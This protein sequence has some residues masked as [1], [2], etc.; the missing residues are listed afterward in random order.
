MRRTACTSAGLL[1]PRGR[2]MLWAMLR[3]R[4]WAVIWP[5]MVWRRWVRW[6]LLTAGGEPSVQSPNHL[7]QQ[8]PQQRH[9]RPLD[10]FT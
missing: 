1:L 5:V 3:T 9:V 4:I 2:A 8:H 7:H 6:L 10:L